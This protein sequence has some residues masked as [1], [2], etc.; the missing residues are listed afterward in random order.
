MH[1]HTHTQHTHAHIHTMY[2]H[3]HVCSDWLSLCTHT[4]TYTTHTRTHTYNV[5][6]HTRVVHVCPS[7]LQSTRPVHSPTTQPSTR[8][9]DVVASVDRV[10]EAPSTSRSNAPQAG[11]QPPE[12]LPQSQQSQSHAVTMVTK[13]RVPLASNPG[14][15]HIDCAWLSW[16]RPGKTAG[17]LGN[18]RLMVTVL[19]GFHFVCRSRSLLRDESWLNHWATTCTFVSINKAQ[20]GF[21]EKL[22][23]DK[24][25][26]SIGNQT[27]D[28]CLW[29]LNWSHD[30]GVIAC[31]ALRVISVSMDSQNRSWKR[32]ADRRRP[33]TLPERV[34]LF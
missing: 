31:H 1:M 25:W 3:T 7:T 17:Y 8:S 2:I 34:L 16:K 22:A 21:E 14:P 29:V 6:T 4:H 5:H 18:V 9:A 11:G 13:V 32:K 26:D 23:I 20:S 30:F 24:Q 10:Q 12:S 27:T 28:T 33:R 19:H 15:D